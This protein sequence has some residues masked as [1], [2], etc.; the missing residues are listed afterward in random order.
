MTDELDMPYSYAYN[1]SDGI[2][3]D[4]TFTATVVDFSDIPEIIQFK[5][6]SC[7]TQYKCKWVFQF[8]QYLSR[9]YYYYYYYYIELTQ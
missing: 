3:H 8:R 7:T 4:N 5:S 9:L 2:K 6:D 1:L